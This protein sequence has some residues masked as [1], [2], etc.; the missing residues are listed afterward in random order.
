[1]FRGSFAAR[2]CIIPAELFYEW[3]KVTCDKQPY[4]IGRADVMPLAF[5]GLWEGWR[6]PDGE[7]LRTFAIIT[8]EANADM[9]KLHDRMPL[10]LEERDW[11]LWLGEEVGDPK[12]LLRPAPDGTLKAWPVSTR[13][14]SPRNNDASLIAPERQAAEG[15]GW[16]VEGKT[17]R[18][19][20]YRQSHT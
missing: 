6:S 19:G 4:A 2:R 7:V 1:M 13:V 15:G 8:T 5:G 17:Q 11:R 3:K 9:A 16:R 10:V 18:E 12:R 20:A 14:N